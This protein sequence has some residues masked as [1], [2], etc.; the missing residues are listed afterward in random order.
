MLMQNAAGTCRQKWHKTDT[1]DSASVPG[2]ELVSRC[3][4]RTLKC[5]SSKQNLAQVMGVSDRAI[6]KVKTELK[7]AGLIDWR[8]AKHNQSGEYVIAWRRLKV[9][10][11]RFRDEWKVIQWPNKNPVSDAATLDKRAHSRL[12]AD[13]MA[14]P[15]PSLSQIIERITDTIEAQAVKAERYQPKSGLNTLLNLIKQGNSA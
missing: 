11:E 15:E 13:L 2:Q 8:K 9:F 7:R 4:V 1:G 6:H 12:W 3:N 10:L 14:L 5:L